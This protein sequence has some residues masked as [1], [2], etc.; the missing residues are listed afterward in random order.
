M[1]LKMNLRVQMDAKSGQLKIE[2]MSDSTNRKNDKYV[3]G[4]LDDT[5]Q[6]EPDN[7]MELHLKVNANIYI[8]KDAQEGA[9]S[10]PANNSVQ[11]LEP[12]VQN[13][14]SRDQEFQ[15]D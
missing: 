2:N 6:G 12:S 3:W 1:H 7:T 14:T 9:P 13:V 8:Y 15:Y 5:I 4:A 11:C 10:E